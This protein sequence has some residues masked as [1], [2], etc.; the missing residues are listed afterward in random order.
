MTQPRILTR[1]RHLGVFV[2]ITALALSACESLPVPGT[3]SRPTESSAERL[4]AKGDYAEA[5]RTYVALAS[6]AI[7]T[8]SDRLKIAA[9]LAW[10]DDNQADRADA[11]INTLNPIAE[12]DP[13]AVD[14]GLARIGVSL[15]NGDIENA[16]D[17]LEQL[18]QNNLPTKARLRYQLYRGLQLFADDEP[19][20]ATS[21]L[22]RREHWLST[23]RTIAAN[24]QTI[25]DGL[26]GSDDSSLREA[27]AATTDKL[28]A[29][30][31]DLVLST[32]AVRNSEN[33]MRAAT[34]DWAQ[35]HPAHPA[36]ATFVGVILSQPQVEFGVPRQIALMLP[37]SGRGRSAARAIRDGFLAAHIHDGSNLDAPRIQIYD[38]SQSGAAVAYEQ[39][40]NDGADLIVGPLTKT[41]VEELANLGELDIPVLALNRLAASSFAP[42]GMLQFALAPEDEAETAARRAISE[43]KRRVIAL[44]PIGDWGERVL[45]A[46][47]GTLQANGGQLLDYELYDPAETDYSAQIERVM[48]ISASVA[49]RNR[50][51]NLVAQPLQFEPRRRQDV[52]LIFMAARAEN[53]RAIKPQLKFHYSGDLPV[54]ATS[55]V[56]AED[57]RSNRDLRNVQYADIPWIVDPENAPAPAAKEFSDYFRSE[58]QVQRLYAMGM[59]AYRLIIPLFVDKG[60][61]LTRGATGILSLGPDGRVR[62]D[63]SWVRFDGDTPI[64]EEPLS[65]FRE[66]ERP[67][68][69]PSDQAP[70]NN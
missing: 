9:A 28:V 53:A 62:R 2:L 42:Y 49:R 23:E 33:A 52:D 11:I 57:G 15:Q 3:S 34:L 69:W 21:F 38:A 26:R 6:S 39:A 48:Q 25:W 45:Q 4:I 50:V 20:R 46:F 8:E 36:N 43:N 24:H 59:D 66:F 37:L 54:F 35:R 13:L 47:T 32:N 18:P 16:R 1:Q 7:G 64:L 27:L 60:E 61:G 65:D 29:G 44:V 70:D 51:R 30:W 5:A 19:A 55:T 22:T 17:A 56:Y 40:R 41:A 63:L 67:L 12:G 68:S 58:P 10:L 31:I 14:L